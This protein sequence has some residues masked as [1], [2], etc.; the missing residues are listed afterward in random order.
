MLSEFEDIYKQISI[1]LH[2]LKIVWDMIFKISERLI[3][4]FHELRSEFKKEIK[5]KYL[6]R[7]KKL[8]KLTKDVVE[9]GEVPEIIRRFKDLEMSVNS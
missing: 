8:L 2:E 9:F 7:H 6:L 1:Y 3:Y 4:I 5:L